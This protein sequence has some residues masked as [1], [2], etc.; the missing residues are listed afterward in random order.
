MKDLGITLVRQFQAVFGAFIG[1]KPEVPVYASYA[2]G[3]LASYHVAA[4]ELGERLK[5]N[6]QAAREQGDEAGALVLI[7]LQLIQEELAELSEGMINRDIVECF[8]ALVD[9]SYV[10]DGTYITLGLSEYKNLGLREVHRSNMSKLDENGKPVTSSAG[11]VVKGP[12]YSP[13]KLDRVLQLPILPHSDNDAVDAFAEAMKDKLAQK[14]AEGRGGWEDKEACSQAELS[15][16]LRN[17]VQK[18]DPVDVANLAMML[19]QRDEGI[20]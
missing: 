3:A 2:T 6:A 17:H 14:R 8:D 20:V 15:H 1:T 19:H 7:R 9:L 13:P 11:R 16:M 5:Q 12:N 18:G 4:A 10:V